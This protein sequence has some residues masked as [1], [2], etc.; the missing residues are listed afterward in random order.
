MTA[1]IIAAFGEAFRREQR[2]RRKET[3]EERAEAVSLDKG[4]AVLPLSVKEQ[5]VR[6]G[7]AAAARRVSATALCADASEVQLLRLTF[8]C[9][10][11][12][13]LRNVAGERVDEPTG[14]HATFLVRLIAGEPKDLFEIPPHAAATEFAFCRMGGEPCLVRLQV[15]DE[16]AD[17]VTSAAMQDASAPSAPSARLVPGRSPAAVKGALWKAQELLREGRTERAME[18]ALAYATDAERPAIALLRA[19]LAKDDDEWLA[20]VNAYVEP[21]GIAPLRLERSSDSRFFRL[22]ANAPP[23]V[24]SG[25]RVT[26]IMPAYNAERTLGL[27]ATSI[28]KQSWSE[29]ELI[30][31]DDCSSDATWDIARRLADADS[32]V[33]VRRNDVNVGPYV[34]KNLALAI[35]SGDYI[36]CHDADD[37]AHPQR[38]EKQV[39]AIVASGGRA[40]ACVSSWLRLDDTG[41][42]CGFTAIGRQSPDGALRLAHVTCMIEAEFMRRYVGHWDS[43]RF[44]ADGE[45]LERLERLLGEGLL[46]LQQLSVLSLDAPRSL[47]NDAAHGISKS[48]GLS[49]TRRAY[50]DAWRRWHATITSDSAYVEFPQLRRPFVAPDACVVR[51]AEAD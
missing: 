34:S 41:R 6:V 29:L 24:S 12:Q 1:E 4:R 36:T 22:T 9:F 19:T 27:A 5:K 13:L 44:G 14:D 31:V 47:T 8:E 32:R 3:G 38:I 40:H 26:V 43:V 33:R 23:A 46:R 45:M 30:I 49:P 17:A 42:F 16:A 50:R 11:A 25:P 51:T 39:E 21:F 48:T 7:A 10:N 15:L 20:N 28:L 2:D 35:A 37:W 18:V